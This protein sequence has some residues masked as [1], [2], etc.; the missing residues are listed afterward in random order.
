MRNRL[1][2]RGSI[3]RPFWRALACGLALLFAHAAFADVRSFRF[4]HITGEHG[5]AQNTVSPLFQDRDGFIW[6]GTQG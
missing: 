6:V 4:Q 1:G 3:N 5:L 2:P